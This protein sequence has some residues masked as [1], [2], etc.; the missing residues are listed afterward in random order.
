MS[1]SIHDPCRKHES[2]EHQTRILKADPVGKVDARRRT[3]PGT[4]QKICS[5]QKLNTKILAQTDN[6]LCRHVGCHLLLTN[7]TRKLEANS[8]PHRDFKNSL[9]EKICHGA[10]YCTREFL[11]AADT[12]D[13]K[14]RRT[15]SFVKEDSHHYKNTLGV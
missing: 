9:R 8:M 2:Y 3:T 5:I 4:I 14:K 6:T 11:S 13:G 15:A 1:K 12:R 10:S 7:H